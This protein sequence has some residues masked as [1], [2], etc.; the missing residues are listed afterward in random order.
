[1]INNK[2]K[3]HLFEMVIIDSNILLTEEMGLM[4]IS[5]FNCIL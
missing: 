1:M 4:I 2:G 3:R 5:L